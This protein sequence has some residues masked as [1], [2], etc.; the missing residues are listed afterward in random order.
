MR[1]MPDDNARNP[2]RRWLL[3]QPPTLTAAH[4]ARQLGITPAALSN[5]MREDMAKRPSLALALRIERLTL[6]Q[7]AP[8]DFNRFGRDVAA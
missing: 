8:S 1:I 2:L 7:V 5:L 6:G 4:V 3:T